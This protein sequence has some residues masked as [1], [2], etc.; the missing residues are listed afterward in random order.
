MAEAA[1]ICIAYTGFQLPLHR[2]RFSARD[3]K[4]WRQVLQGR[5]I[6]DDMAA[7]TTIQCS[8]R[9]T[10]TAKEMSCKSLGS[11]A[12]LAKQAASYIPTSH[13]VALARVSI[14]GLSAGAPR[15]GKR[16]T[17]PAATAQ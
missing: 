2:S 11:R 7:D 4:C 5:L 14:S 10:R 17:G 6:H 9:V 3:S 8:N 12:G 13:S 16:G 15:V 1:V